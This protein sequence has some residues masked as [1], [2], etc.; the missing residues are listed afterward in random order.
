M[1]DSSKLIDLI[2]KK[3]KLVAMLAPSFPINY[4][5]PEIITRLRKLGF[6]YVVEVS[7][8]AKKTNEE[9]LEVLKNNPTSRFITSPCPS[10]VRL[11][12]AKFPNLLKYL[13]FQADSPM[14]ATAKIVKEKY[15][16]FMPVFIGPCIAKKLEASEDHPDLNILVL[17]YNELDQVFAHFNILENK[18]ITSDNFDIEESNTR[19]YPFDGGLTVSAGIDKILKPEEINV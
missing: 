8:G 17:N 15:P 13:A 10:F 16:E 2:N 4:K 7:V 9:V 5:F 11:V 12:R 14:I 3:T 6:N 1:D 18:E 19:I